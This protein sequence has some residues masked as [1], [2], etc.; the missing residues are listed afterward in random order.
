MLK[1]VPAPQLLCHRIVWSFLFLSL[2][3]IFSGNR[4]QFFPSILAPRIVSLYLLAALLVGMNWLIYVW[5][6]NNGFIIESSL[7]YFINPLISVI[8]GVTFLRERLRPLQ[9]VPIGLATAG[10]LYLTISV[11]SFPWIALTLALS[12][13]AYGLVKKIAPLSSLFGL[14]L[15]TGLLFAPALAY[16]WLCQSRGQASFFHSG[17][18]GD[19]LMIGAGLATT[20]PLLFFTSA[21]QRF[22][23]SHLGI[24]QYISPTLQFLMGVIVFKEPFSHARFIGFGFVWL[25]LIIFVAEGYFASKT[26]TALDA[27]SPEI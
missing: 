5:A 1:Y 16:L 23:L 19:V 20:I 17:I 14:T 2:I 6:V 13:A 8:L 21:A 18:T 9:W 7:G 3:V 22:S 26:K 25:A 11:G 27:P 12:F 10:V 4:K 15:E 24:L